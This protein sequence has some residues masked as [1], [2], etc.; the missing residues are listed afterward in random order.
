MVVGFTFSTAVLSRKPF[1]GTSWLSGFVKLYA[2]VVSGKVS[3]SISDEMLTFS[4]RCGFVCTKIQ[5]YRGIQLA[6]W[7]VSIR[8]SYNMETRITYISMCYKKKLNHGSISFH[9]LSCIFFSS[10][11][12]S[13]CFHKFSSF[14]SFFSPSHFSSKFTTWFELM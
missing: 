10:S 13:V 3:V 11:S 6:A 8:R 4:N 14:S 12:S 7:I 2:K 9:G 5:L 1:P